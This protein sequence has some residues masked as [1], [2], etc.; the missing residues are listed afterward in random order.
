[1]ISITKTTSKSITTYLDFVDIKASLREKCSLSVK[2]C[3]VMR[4]ITRHYINQDVLRV[5]QLLEMDFIASPAT[6]HGAI[7]KLVAKKMVILKIDTADGRVKYLIPTN[8]AL[9]LLAELGKLVQA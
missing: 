5:K 1:M 7:K 3:L 4:T 6:L 8:K 9:E 2:E